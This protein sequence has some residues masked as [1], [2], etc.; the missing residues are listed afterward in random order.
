MVDLC[1]FQCP[2]TPF[3]LPFSSIFGSPGPHPK[4]LKV[5]VRVIIVRGLTPFG[6]HLFRGLDRECVLLLSFY[7]SFRIFVV[8]DPFGTNRCK[9][10]EC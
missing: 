7:I 2:E 5:C 4:Q 1:D 6:R 10:S 8:L 9:K 3:W